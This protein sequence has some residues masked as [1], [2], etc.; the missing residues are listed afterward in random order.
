MIPA[1]SEA[2]AGATV[3]Q[4]RLIPICRGRHHYRESSTVSSVRAISPSCDSGGVGLTTALDRPRVDCRSAFDDCGAT[5]L[6]VSGRFRI[7]LV[8]DGAIPG[9][10]D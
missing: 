6:A 2:Q 4:L 10:F 7:Y 3:S 8:N 1:T 9:L 5:R